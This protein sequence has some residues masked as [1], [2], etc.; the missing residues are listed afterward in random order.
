MA[1]ER[2]GDDNVTTATNNEGRGKKGADSDQDGDMA[3]TKEPSHF[4]QVGTKQGAKNYKDGGARQQ[5]TRAPPNSTRPRPRP[6]SRSQGGGGVAKREDEN[7]W[8]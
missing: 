2:D 5:D 3:G 7:T 1:A 6:G 8:M 4:Y